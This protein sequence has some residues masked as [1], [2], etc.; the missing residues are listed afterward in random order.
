[1]ITLLNTMAEHWFTWQFA[2]LWQTAILIAIIWI[3]DLCIH[4]W[5]HPQV[6]YALWMLILVK[7]LI[8]PTWTSPASITSHIPGLA[9]RAA[10]V[11]ER[12]NTGSAVNGT[13]T[14]SPR[15]EQ[16]NQDACVPLETATKTQQPVNHPGL[17]ATPPS[18]GGEF[19]KNSPP[20]KGEY[21]EGGR[22]LSWKTCAMF[23]W[24]VGVIVLSTW[25]IIRLTGLRRQHI[26]GWHGQAKLDRGLPKRF[27]TQLE[28]VAKRLKLKRVP[29]VILTDKVA[30]PAVFGIFRPVLLMPAEK[31][32][33]MSTQDTEHILLHE[34]A[35][36]KRGDLLVHAVYMMLQIAYW[37]NPLLWLARRPMQNLRE[38]CCDATV[39]RLLRDKTVHYRET[40]LETA[41]QLLA[42][43]VDPGLGLLGLFENSNWL[44]TRLK[45]LEKNT[46]KNRPLRIATIIALVAIMTT[47]VL[48][49]A[50]GEKQ[51]IS[52]N[53]DLEKLVIENFIENRDRLESCVLSWTRSVK[54]DGFTKAGRAIDNLEYGGTYQ[55][56]WDGKKTTTKYTTDQI[57]SGTVNSGMSDKWWIK[58]ES[59]GHSYGGHLLSAKPS[60]TG[61]E[62]WLEQVIH[63]YNPMSLDKGIKWRKKRDYISMDWSTIKQNGVK[64]VK[65]TAENIDSREE[66]EKGA[67]SVEF[68]DVLKNYSLISREWYDGS[69][70]LY[71]K[72]TRRYKEVIPNL[73]FPAEVHFQSFGVDGK[74]ELSQ[75]LVL[76]L[77]QCRFND[78]KAVSKDVFG[79]PLPAENPG[80]NLQKNPPQTTETNVILIY[81]TLYGWWKT[82]ADRN[83]EKHAE[84]VIGPKFR[85][86]VQIQDSV[87]Q[88]HELMQF[89]PDWSLSLLSVHWKNKEA[90]AVTGKMPIGEPS[91][92]A[93]QVLVFTLEKQDDRWQIN[94]IDLEELEGLQVENS[95][96]LKSHPDANIWFDNPDYQ[97]KTLLPKSNSNQAQAWV[98]DFFKH[99]YRDITARKTLEWGEPVTHKD[100]NISI[101]YKYEATIWDKDKKIN[102]Q[103]FTFDKNGKFISVEKVTQNTGLNATNSEPPTT[104]YTATLPNGV[105]VELLGICEH[106]SEGK[107]WWSPDGQLME[108]RIKAGSNVQ[109]VYPIKEDEQAV[110]FK[111]KYSN[112]NESVRF[113]PRIENNSY[114]YWI[115][116]DNFIL[117]KLPISQKTCDLSLE[118]ASGKWKTVAGGGAGADLDNTAYTNDSMTDSGVIFYPLEIQNGKVVS[119]I[120]NQLG[121]IADCRAIVKDEKGNLRKPI[122]WNNSGSDV[123]SCESVFDVPLDQIASIQL[124]ARRYTPVTFKNIALRPGGETEGEIETEQATGNRQQAETPSAAKAAEFPG[125]LVFHGR[126]RHR[127][128]RRDIETPGELWLKQS[129]DGSISA[130]AHL[131]WM[132][133]YDIAIGDAHHRLTS[134]RS[135]RDAV[136]DKPGYRIQLQLSDGKAVLTRRGVRDDR[137][138]FE[139]TVPNG[140]YFNPNSRP[141]SYY[142][143]NIFLRGLDLT[144][145]QMK[146]FRVYDWDN[147]GEKLV[148]YT[149]QITHAGKEQIIVPAGTFEA[150]HLVLKQITSADTWFKKRAGHITDYW[151]LDNGIIIRIVRHREPYEMEL[152][153]YTYP[154]NLGEKK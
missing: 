7:L 118:V 74:A 130:I 135:E 17:T 79:I 77:D 116:S 53:D 117:S 40:L 46:W 49:M 131:P 102:D 2:M 51:G 71:M 70:R 148:D 144:S 69:G 105:T 150:N 127:S 26:N 31:F 122:K 64:L 109:S 29:R 142:A 85:T 145:G 138:N 94:D 39:A 115:N 92:G 128:R 76:N 114:L 80:F 108:S 4:K 14:S 55:L 50:K 78:P 1:M 93:Q 88:L 133:S 91:V 104:N 151:V 66:I 5:A 113:R 110:Q 65:L 11:M 15:L 60:Y 56:W 137:D 20:A 134:C 126:Y 89:N 68:F 87:G 99:N 96:F 23:T 16:R 9:H 106:P 90:L 19:A 81:K 152:L 32:K 61:Y 125:E 62:N 3:V 45:W 143:D 132:G 27:Y 47:C 136:Q 120:V 154:D 103:V 24:L 22:G 147:T 123:C 101:R 30:C 75:R 83:Y 112:N 72:E 149:I 139:L 21:S 82:A 25:L 111:L 141:D 8:P 153:D 121:M 98:E 63:W 129:P 58:K 119:R 84:Y 6:R 36:I 41:R 42:E 124:Q 10:T 146:E 140:A 33:N 35:H 97:V 59:G 28:E 44:V 13:R 43:P 73:W 57:Y 48:P 52:S 107:Q 37:F 38:L 95:R 67:R 86:S 18:K 54:D 34:L 12:A 100:G